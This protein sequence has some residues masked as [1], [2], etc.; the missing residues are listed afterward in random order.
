MNKETTSGVGINL[1]LEYID[2]LI[3]GPMTFPF[4]EV[5]AENWFIPGPHHKKLEYI[6]QSTPL[7]FHCVGMNIGGVDPIDHSYL[8]K[9]KELKNI[10]GP[11]HISDHLCFQK[12]KSIN[13]HDLLPFPF[14][15]QALNHC[16]LRVNQIQDYLGEEILIENLSY[17]VQFIENEMEEIDFIN[18]L[19]QKT[20]ANQ[21]L[22]LNNIWVNQQN[23]ISSLN[24]YIE[25]IIWD[26]VKEVHLA[27]AELF[28][29]QY[30]DT[31][32]EVVHQ[33]VLPLVSQW[34]NKLSGL[35]IVYE[36]DAH[37]LPLPETVKI[38]TSIQ[39]A[40]AL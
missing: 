35:P 27:G 29:G 7:T 38:V 3:Q 6:R 39:Q 31:H 1:R 11:I 32:G 28:D 8:D 30:I 12:H 19:C 37:I 9:I 10:Y 14:N 23:N 20:G 24:Y 36:R 17:Y 5:I 34:K 2:E 13:S 21:L 22:D 40:L 18:Q 15:Q 4:L 16:V 33:D 26:K 25:N